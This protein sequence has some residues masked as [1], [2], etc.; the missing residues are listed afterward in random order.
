MMLCPHCLRPGDLQL[1]DDPDQGRVLRCPNPG[2]DY[3]T[4]PVLYGE[5]YHAHP[6]TPV[7]IVG[8]S[9]HGKTV[10]I[11]SLLQEI[12]QLGARWSES[13]FFFTWL[14]EIQ[15]RNAYK[16]IRALREGQLPKGTKTVFQQPQVLRLSN[17]PRVGGSQLVIFDTG[18][19]AFLDSATLADAGK[20][21]RHSSA[22][23][24][25]LSLKKGD[26]YDTPDDVNQ[27][28]TVYLQTMSRMGGRTQ[29]QT[30]VL[31]LTKGDELLHRPDLPESARTALATADYSPAGP[32]WPVLEE[33]SADLENWLKSEKCGYHNLVNL[34]KSRFKAVRYAV[35]SAQGA[36]SDGAS[37]Q[38]GLMPRGVL[39]PLLWLWRLNRE[40]I[41]VQ[42]GKAPALYLNA[43][44]A[45]LGADGG[46]VQLEAGTYRFPAALNLRKPV[47]VRGRGPGRT[48][49]E[50]E[51]P[52]YG[53]GVAAAGTVAFHG[54]TLRRTGPHPG[55]VV[56]VLQGQLDLADVVVTGGQAGTV[57]GKPV[58]GTGVLAA[59]Q[60]KL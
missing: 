47:T 51:H 21:V 3:P 4:V 17:I 56:R 42:N 22:V 24:W 45:I 49:L 46:E 26:P 39:A 37:L 54:L 32:V 58:Q 38:F 2:C 16:R 27:M 5:D 43:T 29:D 35:V 12:Q 6:P 60:S 9:G 53:I 44:E 48:V 41:T 40:P 52:G 50:V 31:V 10:F 19:E 15:M 34:V 20:Y 23:I 28:M 18:G 11:E 33:A 36:P 57:D 25:L 55:D 14:D 7:S 30:L 8:L 1:A 59:R 13:G